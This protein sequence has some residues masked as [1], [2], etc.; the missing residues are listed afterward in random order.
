M[1]DGFEAMVD[2][3]Q[4]FFADLAKNNS[5]DWFEPRKDHYTTEIR[6]P[7]ELF[8]DLVAED[9]SRRTGMAQ[10][11][12]VFRI[13]RD[14]RFSKDKSPYNAHLHML[15]SAGKD[16]TPAFFFAVEPG[17]VWTGMGFFA[18]GGVILTRFRKFIDRHG[19]ALTDELARLESE[20]GVTMSDYGPEPL[21][22]VPKPY[23][24]DHPH[25]EL[26]KRKSLALGAPLASDWREKGLLKSVEA[27]QAAYIPLWTLFTENF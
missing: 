21:K 6:K 16:S 24:P 3:A 4:P 10:T 8:A 9:L 13:H 18:Q 11:P 22:R 14:V 19:D 27:A 2:A 7:A 1:A 20:H 26:L 5:K 15:W 12:K 25:A 17:R 23:D